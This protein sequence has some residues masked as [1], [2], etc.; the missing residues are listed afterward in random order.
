MILENLYVHLPVDLQNILLSAY[1]FRI[2][3]RRYRGGYL[4]LEKEVFDR[5]WW[6]CEQVNCLVCRRLQSIVRHAIQT[7]PYYQSLFA[8]HHIE[9]DDIRGPEDLL[10]LPILEKST[11]QARLDDFKSSLLHRMNCTR[12][13]TSG[14]TGAGIVF[15]VTLEAEREQWAVWWR[16]RARFGID[17]RTWC[18]HFYGKSIVPLD[19]S[20][21]P[22]WRVNYPGRQVFF[23]G[24]HMT[25]GYLPYYVEELNR[26]RP[27]WIQGYPSLLALLATYLIDRGVRLDF[28][29]RVVTIGAESLLA[30]QKRV[31]EEAFRA[32]CRQH[33]GLTEA[34]VNISECPEGNL[35]VDED[36]GHIEFLP[37]GDGAYKIIGTGY[38]NYAF[39]LIR[40]DTGDVAELEDPDRRCPCGRMGRL[41]KSIDGRIEDYLLTPDGR[42]IGRL[43]HIFKDMIHIRE[44]QI[45]QDDLARVV[46][47]VAK[48]EGYTEADEQMLLDEAR[49]RIGNLIHVDIKYVDAI[50]RTR[51]GKIRLVVSNLGEGRLDPRSQA[52]SLPLANEP[53]RSTE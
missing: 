50:E 34:L 32:T 47:R 36:Y 27:E 37:I 2:M 6:S 44:C 42:R 22:F 28:R 13:H 30:H 52:M 4:R 40:Y 33:Y 12:A 24:Y 10:R 49:K 23:S 35:H 9:P 51:R 25:S 38:T 8:Q 46:F 43:D 16:Y 5:E 17:R 48:G 1:G 21:P 41:V 29:P 7:S 45:I 31:I 26:R 20:R 15:P 14:T 53:E 11:V 18:A 19:Q 3:T 39:P